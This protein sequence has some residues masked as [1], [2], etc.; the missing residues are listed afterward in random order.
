MFLSPEI[1][2]NISVDFLV[3][4]FCSIVFLNA[5]LI[6]RYF[7]IKKDTPLQY[8]LEKRNYLSSVVAKFALSLKIPMFFYFVF[9]LDKLSNV[10]PG[11][12]CAAGVVTAS[13]YG[14]GLLFLKLLNIYLFGLWLL[15]DKEDFN[16]K[17]FRYTKFKF[18]FFIVIF[19]LLLVEI[20]TEVLYFSD[21]DVSRIVSCCGALFNPAKTSLLGSL[22]M[23][24]KT[25]AVLLFYIVY[26]ML[27]LAGFLKRA[28]FY[29]LLNIIFLFVSVIA[30]IL[31][32][33]PYIYELPT[34]RCP[35]CF[36]QKEYYYAGYF[37]YI[38][39][40]I[41][42]FSGIASAFSKLFLK[43]EKNLYGVSLAFNTL[44]VI[45]LSSY[46]IVYYLKNGV[47]L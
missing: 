21:I 41:G 23:I 45:I 39:L 2:I 16:T 14:V 30:I 31:F 47:W 43:K 20:V 8:R 42:T 37:I 29:G 26:A 38:S 17:D 27:L 33:S 44:F 19:L 36:L 4:I 7:D 11:A 13:V 34:H 28:Y 35:F 18:R 5:F 15:S 6:V 9:T 46:V 10:I 32:F 12:M 22:L 1:L 3:L 40:F 24:E 25:Y